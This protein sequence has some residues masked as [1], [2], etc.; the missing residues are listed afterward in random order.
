MLCR[1][2]RHAL[3]IQARVV[4][5]STIPFTTWACHMFPNCR[6]FTQVWFCLGTPK[7]FKDAVSWLWEESQH[8]AELQQEPQLGG[9][10]TSQVRGDEGVG[11]G[12]EGSRVVFPTT[13]PKEAALS[14]HSSIGDI[15]SLSI[16]SRSY[17]SGFNMIFP[18]MVVRVVVF[19][20]KENEPRIS[21]IAGAM[22]RWEGALALSRPMLRHLFL[23]RYSHTAGVVQS[24]MIGIV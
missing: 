13:A 7:L 20:K 11:K 14:S 2:R 8:T 24:H 6:H 9:P 21:F 5:K 12:Q 22:L 4:G 23:M 17:D 18:V 1:S 19:Y 10:G 3:N 16:R 15:L